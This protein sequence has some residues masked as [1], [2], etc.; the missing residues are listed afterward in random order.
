[1]VR[2]RDPAGRA[3][4]VV[5][6]NEDEIMYAIRAALELMKERGQSFGKIELPVTGGKIRHVNALIEF[7]DFGKD[8]IIEKKQ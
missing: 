8:D 2:R 1:M 3:L 4:Q 7:G 5:G 6:M